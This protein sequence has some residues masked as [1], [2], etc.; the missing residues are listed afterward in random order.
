[1]A[2]SANRPNMIA[3]DRTE[4]HPAAGGPP[5]MGG[6]AGGTSTVRTGGQGATGLNGFNAGGAMSLAPNVNDPAK[7]LSSY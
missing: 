7:K 1:M 6:K 5:A 4:P 3:K 2:S